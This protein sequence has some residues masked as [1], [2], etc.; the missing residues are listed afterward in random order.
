VDADCGSGKKCTALSTAKTCSK[1]L[2][3][4]T[5]WAGKGSGGRVREV[6]G[7]RG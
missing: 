5:G 6:G 1:N 4:G 2:H 7:W 3:V